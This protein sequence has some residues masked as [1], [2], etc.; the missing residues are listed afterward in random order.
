MSNL[1]AIGEIPAIEAI[2]HEVKFYLKYSKD[3]LERS[4]SRVHFWEE[5]HNSFT[6]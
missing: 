1:S 6:I 4:K 2:R 3:L 5:S